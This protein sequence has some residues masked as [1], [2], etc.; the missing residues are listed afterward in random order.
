M[1]DVE[2]VM[3]PILRRKHP[4]TLMK[5]K[6]FSE[7]PMSAE[8]TTTEKKLFFGFCREGG[9]YHDFVHG[10]GYRPLKVYFKISIITLTGPKKSLYKMQ[11]EK[12][13]VK[14]RIF[15]KDDSKKWLRRRDD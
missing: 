11:T 6:I 5:G 7:F 10:F 3:M 1:N 2:K 12:V 9:Y 8:E 13:F 15:T 14:I 4:P